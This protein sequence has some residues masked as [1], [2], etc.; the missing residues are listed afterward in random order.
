M[1]FDLGPIK[2]LTLKFQNNPFVGI[3]LPDRFSGLN[4]KTYK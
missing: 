2:K 3:L 1:I 4:Q